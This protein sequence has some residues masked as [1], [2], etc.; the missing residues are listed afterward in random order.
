[1]SDRHSFRHPLAP[2]PIGAAEAADREALRHLVA[3]YGHGIDRRDYAL[4]LSLYHEDGTDDHAP[5]YSGSAKGFVAWLP[6]MMARWK[7]TSHVTSQALY[8]VD[9]DRADGEVTARTWHLTA[10]GTR[11]F[12]AWGRYADRY[13]KRAG[14]W[15]FAHRAFILDH[16]EDLPVVAGDDFGSAGVSVGAAGPD[17]PVYRR[18]AL[19]ARSGPA[20]AP[21]HAPATPAS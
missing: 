11:Q 6:G 2:R 5:Y 4:V 18:L 20:H 1:M 7:A 10:D 16:A 8:A 21:A 14:I 15:R 3:A 17:D 13:E 19:F 9:G 12:I